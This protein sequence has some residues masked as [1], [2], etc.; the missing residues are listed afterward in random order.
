LV[1]KKPKEESGFVENG[2]PTSSPAEIPKLIE[3]NNAVTGSTPDEDTTLSPPVLEPMMET[4]IP[5]TFKVSN[6]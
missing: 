2:V 6:L 1:I 4:K 5:L 3:F